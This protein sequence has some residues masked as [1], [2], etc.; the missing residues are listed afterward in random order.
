[1]TQQSITS[2]EFKNITI[3]SGGQTGADQGALEGANKAGFITGGFIP[4]GFK[5]EKG[6]M[7]ELGEK[8]HMIES[9]SIDYV[10]RTH[11][12]AKS[13]SMTIWFGSDDSTGFMAT[14]KAC[15]TYRKPFFDVTNCTEDDIVKLIKQQRPL[16]L[17]V[18]GNRESKCVGIQEM[19]K[20]KIYNVLN[21][22][23]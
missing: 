4:K 16:I 17:N 8:F 19:V 23:K 5:T 13:S 7:P 6:P 10:F 11:L 2:Y 18:A 9:S 3:I 14:Q 12:N 22:L 1:M 15:K 21:K 20:N